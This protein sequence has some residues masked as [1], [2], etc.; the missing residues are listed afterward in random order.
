LRASRA[1]R[2]RAQ[3]WPLVVV[4]AIMVLVFARL[5]PPSDGRNIVAWRDRFHHILAEHAVLAVL[6][7][8]AIYVCASLCL[9]ALRS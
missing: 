9:P 8:V 2:W 1:R 7:Y 4:G 3:R 5:A 6:I